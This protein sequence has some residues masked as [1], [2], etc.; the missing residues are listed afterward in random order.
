ME[1]W[2]KPDVVELTE[3]LVARSFVLSGALAG[4]A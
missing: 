3:R 1:W 4:L 2:S